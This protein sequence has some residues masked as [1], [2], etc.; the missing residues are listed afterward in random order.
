MLLLL[1][2]VLTR[3]DRVSHIAHNLLSRIVLLLHLGPD[4]HLC[5]GEGFS[6]INGAL[7]LT[8]VVKGSCLVFN[9]DRSI[10]LVVHCP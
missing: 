1:N 4:L 8:E 6:D 7:R 9:S 3:S 2:G 10:L 5:V